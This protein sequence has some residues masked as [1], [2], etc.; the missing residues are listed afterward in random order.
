MKVLQRAATVKL[1]HGWI[2]TYAQ[3][4]WQEHEPSPLCIVQATHQVSA[5]EISI[6]LQNLE[7]LSVMSELRDDAAVPLNNAIKDKEEE[8]RNEGTG[9][10]DGASGSGTEGSEEDTEA[11]GA[12]EQ[13]KQGTGTRRRICQYC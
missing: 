3:L 6:A 8:E 4:C 2:L 12:S 13:K 1:M 11:D 5:R 7:T 9:E 10:S